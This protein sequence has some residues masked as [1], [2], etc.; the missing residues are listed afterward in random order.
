VTTPQG[1]TEAAR[2]AAARTGAPVSNQRISDAIRQSGMSEA[3]VR[4]RLRAAGYDPSM[5]DPFFGNA[6][7]QAQGEARPEFAA[8]LRAMGIISGEDS[9]ESEAEKRNTADSAGGS[10]AVFGKD[11]FRRAS[12][13]FDP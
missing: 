1:T 6:A 2:A 13:V 12:S 10:S 7:G 5:A 4:D 11:V 8:A 3:Q 9:E